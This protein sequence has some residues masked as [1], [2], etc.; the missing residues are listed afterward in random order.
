MV[1]FS[2]YRTRNE[3]KDEFWRGAYQCKDVKVSTIKLSYEQI[4]EIKNN[5]QLRSKSRTKPRQVPIPIIE[6]EVKSFDC[7]YRNVCLSSTLA[8]HIT[9]FYIL[10]NFSMIPLSDA[11]DVQRIAIEHNYAQQ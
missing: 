10:F 2:G 4:V 1:F 5:L 3:T 7:K 9:V 11:S 8:A 6:V